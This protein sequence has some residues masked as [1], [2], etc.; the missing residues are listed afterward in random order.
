MKPFQLW[1]KINV[2]ILL[3]HKKLRLALQSNAYLWQHITPFMVNSTS[4]ERPRFKWDMGDSYGTVTWQCYHIN[5]KQDGFEDSCN[6]PD[7][8][9]DRSN[10]IPW[11]QMCPGLLSGTLDLEGDWALHTLSFLLNGTAGLCRSEHLLLPLKHCCC[12]PRILLDSHT[13]HLDNITENYHSAMQ[14]LHDAIHNSKCTVLKSN[15]IIV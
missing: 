6:L 5:M 3:C 1:G 7:P 14:K 15:N 11:A 13:S 2:E 12:S 4:C 8:W 10:Q 9:E